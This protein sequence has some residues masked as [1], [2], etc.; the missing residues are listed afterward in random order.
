MSSQK[1]LDTLTRRAAY[2]IKVPVACLSLVN[3]D[4]RLVVS[5]A[6]LSAPLA[7]LLTWPL[8]RHLI[9]SR[10]PLAIPDV[11]R[12][13]LMNTQ[14]AVQDGMVMAFAGAPL[15]TRRGNAIGSLFVMDP[16][17]RLWMPDQIEL[18]CILAAQAMNDIEERQ[19][20][21]ARWENA[22]IWSRVWSANFSMTLRT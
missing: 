6:G 1:L 12:H 4:E 3:G 11:R 14:P 22:A 15:L 21:P 8:C 17:P 7:I 9:A 13:P 5:C 20:A 19:A 2:S 10:L 18:L 16:K